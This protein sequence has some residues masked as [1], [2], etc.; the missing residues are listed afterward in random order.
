M[1]GG[2]GVWFIRMVVAGASLVASISPLCAADS[3]VPLSLVGEWSG[4]WADRSDGSNSG[5]YYVTIETDGDKLLVSS[6]QHHRKGIV[7]ARARGEIRDH[8]LIYTRGIAG[9][10]T[11][12]ADLA[13]EGNRMTGTVRSPKDNW[14]VQ[15]TKVK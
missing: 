2:L 10:G 8:H 9:G 4:S 14:D 3:I 5:R 7:K 1:T 13:V 15:L 11:M 12:T 6:E